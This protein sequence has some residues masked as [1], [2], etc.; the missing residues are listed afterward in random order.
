[1]HTFIGDGLITSNGEK[2]R[3][4]RRLIQPYF[5]VNLLEKYV[6]RFA[7]CAENMVQSLS[8]QKYVKIT[9]HVNNCVFNILHKI[10]L[11]VD[12]NPGDE[13]PFKSG[14][15]YLLQRIAKP[16]L[17][18]EHIFK[19]S[20][21]SKNEFRITNEFQK[22][23]RKILNER[24]EER[25]SKEFK[26][27]CLLDVFVK[28]AETTD[29]SEE[30]IIN[31]SVTFM[32]AGQESVA[33]G[34]AFCL[35]YL[36]K[37]QDIQEKVYQEIKEI[38][39][40]DRW[41]SVTIEQLNQMNYLEQCIKETLRLMP[42]VPIMGRVLTTDVVLGN[43]T[44][45]SGTNLLVSPFIT[46]RLPHIFPDPSKFDPERFSQENLKKMHPF[47]FIPFSAGPRNCIGYKFAYLEMKTIVA[48]LIK[49]YQFS[50]QPDCEEVFVKYRVTLRARGGI[51]LNIKPRNAITKR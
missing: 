13:T 12:L 6:D 20:D 28:L 40:E 23:I 44:I 49:N 36:A 37:Y 1:M 35:Y 15:L 25:K 16:W 7:E 30:D 47:S 10:I 24:R 43:Y 46:H 14:E 26:E 42:S 31:E 41:K 32:L 27:S 5:Q 19:H 18:L 21:M 39:F 29:F 17:L 48:K 38:I 11:G 33:T 3:K 34:L 2:W 22:Y 51:W 50:L 45:P 4:N 8:Q 9:N